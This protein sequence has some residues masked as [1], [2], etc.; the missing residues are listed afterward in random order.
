MH[1]IATSVEWRTNASFDTLDNASQLITRNLYRPRPH[2]RY[3]LRKLPELL[4]R[5]QY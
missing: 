1:W 3:D 4:K 2:S 5:P